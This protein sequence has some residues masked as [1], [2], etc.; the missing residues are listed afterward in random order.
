ML[1][2]GFYIVGVKGEKWIEGGYVYYNLP[3]KLK[4]GS[5]GRTGIDDVKRVL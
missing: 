3:A 1:W 4:W 2:S 5:M